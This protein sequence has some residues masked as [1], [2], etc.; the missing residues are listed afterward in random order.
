MDELSLTSVRRGRSAGGPVRDACRQLRDRYGVRHA[1]V[2]DHGSTAI[3]AALSALRLLAPAGEGA[4]VTPC[5]V[6]RGVHSAAAL[7]GWAT[8]ALADVDPERGVVTEASIEAAVPLDRPAAIVAVDGYAVKPAVDRLRTTLGCPVI[9][10]ASLSQVPSVDDT[11][12]AADAC[13]VS[14][15]SNKLLSCG[16]GGVVLSDR[17]DVAALV[18][19]IVCDGRQWL[20]GIQPEPITLGFNGMMNDTTGA[21]LVAALDR[22]HEYLARI[23]AGTAWIAERADLPHWIDRGLTGTGNVFALP[24]HRHDRGQLDAL[25]VPSGA[26]VPPPDARLR[27]ILAAPRI[28]LAGDYPGARDFAADHTLVPHWCLASLGERHA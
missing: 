8:V 11:G 26:P 3:R 10:D 15:Q 14:F 7:S 27:A 13:V 5:N 28:V 22:V 19:A 23:R 2:V 17:P 6:W 4:V 9:E 21:G 1:V 16:E 12:L 24:V 20:D 18:E 25:D